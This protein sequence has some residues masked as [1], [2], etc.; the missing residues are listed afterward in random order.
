LRASLHLAAELA[1]A[2]ESTVDVLLALT[3]RRPLPQGFR[4]L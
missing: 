1:D 4:V 2:K 3:G